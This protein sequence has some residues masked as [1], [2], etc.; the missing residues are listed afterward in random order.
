M[1]KFYGENILDFFNKNTDT[2]V[3]HLRISQV[4]GEGMR[5]DRIMRIMQNELEETN[6]ITVFGSGRRVSN[7]I[8]IDT[9]LERIVFFIKYNQV[10]VFNVGD[11]HFSYKDIALDIIKN[12][13]N[14]KSII[15]IIDIG[16]SSKC[17]INGDKFKKVEDSYGL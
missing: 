13:G 3:V 1:A 7:F 12:Y 16:V 9:L 15:D 5:E 8:D 11:K 4:Y 17:L 14:D 10:G 6:K 2:K